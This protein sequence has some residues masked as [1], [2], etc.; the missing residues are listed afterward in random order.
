MN[1]MNSYLKKTGAASAKLGL[2]QPPVGRIKS[3]LVF[4]IARCSSRKDTCSGCGALLKYLMRFSG[5][6][7]GRPDV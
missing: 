6:V 2:R 4:Y 3:S 1:N 7:F 5:R